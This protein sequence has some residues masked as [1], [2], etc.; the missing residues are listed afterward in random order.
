MRWGRFARVPRCV[1][2]W[3][4]AEEERYT[5][6]ELLSKTATEDASGGRGGGALRARS[7]IRKAGN[8]VMASSPENQLRGN[9][10]LMCSEGDNRP[11]ARGKRRK[12]G[13]SHEFHVIRGID[14]EFAKECI[15]GNGFGK[16]DICPHRG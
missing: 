11:G 3:S 9:E 16:G 15:D 13:R 7:L 1:G 8:C 5:V 12:E 14:A 2:V 4:S 6:D 10:W